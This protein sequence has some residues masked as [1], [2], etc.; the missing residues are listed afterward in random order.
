[1]VFDEFCVICD[2]VC[3]EC[4]LDYCEKWVLDDLCID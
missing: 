2:D 4:L 1:M 3:V